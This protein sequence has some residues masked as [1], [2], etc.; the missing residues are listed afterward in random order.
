MRKINL[1]SLLFIAASIILLSSCSQVRQVTT[2]SN[3]KLHLI[4]AD[5]NKTVTATAKAENPKVI[6]RTEPDPLPAKDHNASALQEEKNS[7]PK[8]RPV[9][10]PMLHAFINKES[11]TN[12][13]TEAN[14]KKLQNVDKVLDRLDKIN[15]SLSPISFAKKLMPYGHSDNNKLLFIWIGCLVLAII[16][17]A[18]AYGAGTAGS[19][20]G[21]VIFA[22]LAYLLWLA[23]VVLFIV[24][25]VK[26]L[27]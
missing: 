3:H 7:A 4:N 11:K 15:Q 26:L 13:Q 1:Q 2:S 10:S 25:L 19:L 6:E 12:S 9:K 8:V 21:L 18:I 16:F 23:G 24:W 14:N 27:S 5:R 22:I 20:G 17:Y